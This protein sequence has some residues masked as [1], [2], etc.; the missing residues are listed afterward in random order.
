MGVTRVLFSEIPLSTLTAFAGPANAADCGVGMAFPPGAETPRLSTVAEGFEPMGEF[1]I[2]GKVA[3][4]GVGETT[5][6]KHSQSPHAEFKLALMAILAA[7]EDAGIDPTEIDG[8]ASYSNDRNDPSRIAAA[9]G[10]RELAFSNMQW[11]AAAGAAG[12]PPSPTRPRPSPAAM[13]ARWSCSAR[14]PRD[15]SSASVRRRRAVL[16]PATTPSPC[17]TASCRPRRNT[18]C[19]TSASPMST[20][21]S[22]RRSGRSPWPPTTMRSRI[23]AP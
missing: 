11:R 8:F 1:T 19:A 9:L 2:R 3:V 12:R 22:A 13:H 15:S 16:R 17:L 23:R 21:S 6:W 10:C 18:P 7:A 14:S 4:A 20:A 5:Y